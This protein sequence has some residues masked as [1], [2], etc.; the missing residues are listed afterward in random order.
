M[1]DQDVLDSY[2]DGSGGSL[3]IPAPGLLVTMTP[4]STAH[5]SDL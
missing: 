3:V 4:G 5:R 1:S 2:L